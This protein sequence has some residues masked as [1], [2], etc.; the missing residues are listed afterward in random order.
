MMAKHNASRVIE[1]VSATKWEAGGK[2]VANRV[3]PMGIKMK[4]FHC[5]VLTAK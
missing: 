3:H 1:Q 2:T 4:K 5:F